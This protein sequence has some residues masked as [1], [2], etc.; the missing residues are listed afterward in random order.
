MKI[1]KIEYGILEDDPAVI[2]TYD[3]GEFDFFLNVENGGWKYDPRA[4]L[5]KLLDEETFK[6][7]FPD[8]KM[9]KDVEKPAAA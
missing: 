4:L 5:A 8:L 3:T 9:P 2:V 7:L 6:R 1:K